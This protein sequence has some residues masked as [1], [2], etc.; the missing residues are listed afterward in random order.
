MLRHSSFSLLIA[1]S[2]FSASLFSASLLVLASGCA[3]QKKVV[4]KPVQKNSSAKRLNTAVPA[5]KVDIEVGAA[6]AG[7]SLVVKVRGIGRGHTSGQ[8]LENP[9]AWQISANHGSSPLRQVLAG[10]AKVSRQPAGAALGDQWDIEV[11]FM[12]AFALPDRAGKVVIRV[13][14]PSG[15][16]AKQEISVEAPAERLSLL[17]K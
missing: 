1:S 17:V 6:R 7:H 10:P 16:I 9:K 12:V 14:A 13:Q 15:E 8:A 4:T 5:E 3:S 2:L 11:D